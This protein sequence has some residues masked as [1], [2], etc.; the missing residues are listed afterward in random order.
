[1]KI[2]GTLLLLCC[3]NLFM[4]WAWYGHLKKSSTVIDK[5]FI[6]IILVS[7]GIAFFEYCFMIPANRLGYSAGMS[8]AQLKIAQEV[9]TL[10]IFIPFAIYFMGERWKMDYLWAFICIMGA[11]FFVNREQLMS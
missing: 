11:V 6:L 5:P 9:I 10:C 7:W 8:L 1:M 3:S 2:I 4:T